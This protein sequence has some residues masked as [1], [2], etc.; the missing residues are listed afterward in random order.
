MNG[1]IEEKK[2][3]TIDAAII[4][5]MLGITR[6]FASNA[7]IENLLKY[8]RVKGNV[9]ICALNDTAQNNKRYLEIY[10]G[11]SISQ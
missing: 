10:S 8:K 3:V 5:P 4:K 2:S 9:P 1:M 6:K 11:H 7:I